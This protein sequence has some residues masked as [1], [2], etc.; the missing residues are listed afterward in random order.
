MEFNKN[1]KNFFYQKKSKNKINSNFFEDQFYNNRISHSSINLTSKL[2]ISKLLND[3]Y[4][5][6]EELKKEKDIKENL[7]C[8]FLLGLNKENNK[9]VYIKEYKIN[10]KIKNSFIN[11]FININ[12]I[13]SN[14]DFILKYIEDFEDFYYHYT[15]FEYCSNNLHNYLIEN[16]KIKLKNDEIF[17]IFLQ[18]CLTIC[19]LQEYEI[20]H[21]TLELKFIYYN[22]NYIKKRKIFSI[23]ISEFDNSREKDKLIIEL[24][25]K[26]S[27]N[28]KIE[29]KEKKEEELFKIDIFQLGVIG[30]SLIYNKYPDIDNLNLRKTDLELLIKNMLID[31]YSKRY[32]I[33]EVLTSNYFFNN[34]KKLYNEFDSFGFFDKYKSGDVS[35]KYIGTHG[36]YYGQLKLNEYFNGVFVNYFNEYFIGYLKVKKKTIKIINKKHRKIIEN[37]KEI[38][39]IFYDRNENLYYGEWYNNK[40]EGKGLLYYDGNKYLGEFK[41]GKKNGKGIEYYNNNEIYDGEWKNNL[42]HGKGRY[43]FKNGEIYDGEWKNNKNFGNCI[44]Y[45]N[46]GDIFNGYIKDNKFYNKGRYYNNFLNTVFEG[47]WFDNQKEGKGIYFYPDFSYKIIYFKENKE[48]N[49]IDE[50]KINVL[51]NIDNKDEK[52]YYDVKNGEKFIGKIKKKNF[53]DKTNIKIEGILYNIKGEKFEGS[54]ENNEYKEGILYYNNKEKYNGK[55]KN[56]QKNGTGIYYY[57]DKNKYEGSWEDDLKNGKGKYF[58]KNGNIFKGFWKKGKIIFGKLINKKIK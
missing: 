53:F 47:F 37:S 12:K 17:Q 7:F 5:I 25:K 48:I 22:I 31:E 8:R 54:F 20:I 50:N 19:F 6:L 18:L 1:K 42:K 44:Y 49:F 52:V 36:L 35:K 55:W 21:N 26:S 41:N 13:L 57:E 2:S 27:K 30:Y 29:K 28:I 51:E 34:I 56:N 58:Y 3:K 9:K 33:Y 45:F 43:Y 10:K 24:E 11:D 14:N 38:Y 46:N 39:G 23:K 15:I 32:N 16:K 40:Y 4:K